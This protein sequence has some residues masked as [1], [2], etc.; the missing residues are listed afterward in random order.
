MG[1]WYCT[2]ED[3]KSALDIAAT[4][5]TDAQVYRV[6]EHSSRGVEG[7][8][9]RRFY[10]QVATRYF[11][12][13]NYQRAL[14][15][16]LWLESNELADITTVVTGSTTLPVGAYFLRRSDDVDEPPY[17][18]VELNLSSTSAWS[19][20]GTHQ[21]SI[22]ITGT[23]IGCPVVSDVAGALAAAVSTT[24]TITAD[25]TNSTVIGV[26]S[27]IKIDSERMIVRAK[28]QLTTGQTIQ[29]ALGAS[30][31]EVSVS[32]SDGTAFAVGETVLIDSERMLIIDV[33]GNTLAVKRA[34]D[35]SVLA[36]HAGSTIYAPRR[37]TVD[38][39]VLGTT[40][41]T[42]LNAAPVTKMVYPGPVTTLTI[43][44]SLTILLQEGAGYARTAGSGDNVREIIG[45]SL[46]DVREEA[47]AANGR[48]ARL[49]VI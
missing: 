12:W 18:H 36:A 32:V 1:I 22:A 44:E 17:D 34:Y 35:G 28:S 11:D 37:L 42:H 43:A 49:G 26:G 14:P 27:L 33:A 6:I 21:R 25:V 30:V 5:R 4:A 29:A 31:A 3:V 7:R 47:E 46:G 2:G 9:H 40:A 38:R 16:R 48:R 23:Y 8:L 13:P 15:W 45:R 19:V 10:P 20:G 41:A 24:T 39:G